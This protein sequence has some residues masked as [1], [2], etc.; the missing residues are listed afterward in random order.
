MRNYNP[1]ISLDGPGIHYCKAVAALEAVRRSEP[2]VQQLTLLM[3]RYQRKFDRSTAYFEDHPE[4]AE[5]HAVNLEQIDGALNLAF[6]P[7]IQHS[8]LAH[9]SCA[10][11]LEAIV[12]QIASE[13]LPGAAW[14]E[15]ER[16]STV[17]KWMTLPPLL[18]KAAFRMGASPMQAV[19]RV[20]RIRNQLTHFKPVAERWV[21]STPPVFLSKL[22]L[23]AAEVARSVDQTAT[24]IGCLC[25]GLGHDVPDWLAGQAVSFLHM[26]NWDD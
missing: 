9:I 20:V 25:T 22:G 8:T 6:S 18:G 23:S 14:T 3:E 24:S 2:K 21:P 12:N 4:Q 1:R 10:C 5:R 15:F 11:V 26:R 7:L 17:A 13:M 16:M 19:C